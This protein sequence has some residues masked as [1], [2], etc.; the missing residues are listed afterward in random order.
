MATKPSTEQ[1]ITDLIDTF[2]ERD[3]TVREKYV[4]RE[5]LRGLVR[6]AKSEQMLEMKANVKKLTG[7]I[8]PTVQRRTKAD[9][10]TGSMPRRL[11]QQLEF[12]QFY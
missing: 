9:Q 3:L 2:Y 11:P 12:N 5:S 4:F 7:V 8:T 1:V 6:L 10:H